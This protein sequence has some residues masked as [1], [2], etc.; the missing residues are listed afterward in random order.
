LELF[1]S[2]GRKMGLVFEGMMRA[3]ETRIIPYVAPIQF[4]GTLIY[5]YSLGEKTTN[6]R[7]ISAYQK[8]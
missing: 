7:M 1:D 6:G 5:R 2:F 8:E 3:G 4:K